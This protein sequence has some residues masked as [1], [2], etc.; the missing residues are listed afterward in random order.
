MS[1]FKDLSLS[2]LERRDARVRRPYNF[3]ARSPLITGRLIIVWF[4]LEWPRTL[5]TIE[6]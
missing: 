1:A 5:R 4:D 6:E 2:D 3:S